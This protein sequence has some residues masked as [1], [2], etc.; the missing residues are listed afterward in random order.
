[1]GY[2]SD[3]TIAHAMSTEHAVEV[4]A[5]YTLLPEVQSFGLA[6]NWSFDLR[7]DM[8]VIW[9][10]MESVKWEDRYGDVRGILALETLLGEFEAERE[11]PYAS[12]SIRVGEDTAD[13]EERTYASDEGADNFRDHLADSLQVRTTVECGLEC[14]EEPT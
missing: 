10:A 13:I 2:R 8:T 12:V 6:T 7:H 1:M 11:F 14:T 4:F 3:V 5:A 9:I